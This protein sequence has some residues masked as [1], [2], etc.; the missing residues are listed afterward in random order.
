M[1]YDLV[2]SIRAEQ[3][4]KHAIYYYDQINLKLGERFFIELLEAY[5]KIS[6]TPQYYSFISTNRKTKIRDI[7]LPSFPYVVIF[8]VVKSAVY[9]IA[10]KNTYLKPFIS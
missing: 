8:R 7:K 10:V 1:A 9:V 2:I 5:Q 4:T 6:E 3:D